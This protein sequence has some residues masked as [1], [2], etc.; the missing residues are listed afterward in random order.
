[1]SPTPF[2]RSRGLPLSVAAHIIN[3]ADAPT[4]TT[5]KRLKEALTSPRAAGARGNPRRPMPPRNPFFSHPTV[6]PKPAK[7]DRLPLL[8]GVW[9]GVLLLALAVVVV[10]KGKQSR[11][12]PVPEKP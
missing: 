5:E 6:R 7:P 1:M 9:G 3:L 12:E 10:A 4:P 11:R 8:V 2:H